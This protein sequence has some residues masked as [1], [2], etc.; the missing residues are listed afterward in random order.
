MSPLTAP[1]PAAHLEIYLPADRLH[2][3][4]RGLDLPEQTHGAALYADLTGFTPL[5]EKLRNQLGSRRGAEQLGQTLE[6]V[7]DALIAEVHRFGGSVIGFS[8]DAVTCWFDDDPQVAPACTPAVER[9]AAAGQGMQRQIQRF[10]ALPLPDGDQAQLTIKV[11]IACGPARRLLVGDPQVH[12]IEVIAGETLLRMA[13]GEHLAERGQVL[14]DAAAV[15]QLRSGALFGG[16]RRAENGA[17]FYPLLSLAVEVE[18][19]PWPEL[20][21]AALPAAVLRPWLLP[22]VY[23]RLEQGLGDYLTELRPASALFMK[24]GGLDFDRDPGAGQALDQFIR[25]VQGVLWRYDGA[26]AQVTLGEKGSFLYA[27][28]GA[29]VTHE[30]DPFRA[31]SAALELLNPPETLVG[32]AGVQIGLASGMLRTGSY[33]SHDR[34]SYSALGDEV[35]LAARLMQLAGPGEILASGQFQEALGQAFHWR[36]LPPVQIKGKAQPAPVA[37]LLGAAAA[38]LPA[39]YQGEMIGRQ[40]ELGQLQEFLA[41]L[42]ALRPAFAGLMLLFGDPGIGKSR[43]LFELRRR[44][45]GAGGLLWLEGPADPV[46]GLSLA[47][48]R[49]L[50]RRYFRQ[51]PE[52]PAETNLERFNTVLDDL[53]GALLAME[54]REARAGELRRQLEWTRAMLGALVDLYWP[55]SLYQ[56]LEPKQRF[57]NTLRAVRALLLAE[58]LRRPVV[59]VLED[60][61]A[62][63]SDSRAQITALVRSLRGYPLAVILAGRFGVGGSRLDIETDPETPQFYLDLGGLGGDD[64][65]LLAAQALEISPLAARAIDDRLAELLAEKTGGNPLFV[66]QLTHELRA[67]GLL[68]P[69]SLT[70]AGGWTAASMELSETPAS[71]DALLTARLDRLDHHLKA[72]V[73]TAAILG[74]EFEPLVLERMLPA[75]SGLVETL[76]LGLAEQIW[77]PTGERHYR[78]RHQLLRDA[79]YQMQPRQRLE[80]LHARA[81]E[82]IELLHVIDLPPYLV[83]LAYHF[84]QARQHVSAFRYAL[85]A[86]AQL[87]AQFANQAAIELFRQAL[88]HA[89]ELGEQQTADDLPRLHLALGELLVTAG[90]QTQADNHLQNALQLATT[91]QQPE[92]AA[93][94]CR[95]LARLS[96]LRGEYPAALEWAGRGLELLGEDDNAESAEILIQAGLTCSRQGDYPQA[97]TRAAAGLLAAERSGSLSAQARASNL[98]GHLAFLRGELNR[99]VDLSR[100]ALDLYQQAGDLGGM[101]QV[102]NRLGSVYLS[103]GD[104]PA[105][106]HH[107]NQARQFFDQVGNRYNRAFTENNLGIL[108]LN[109]GR[110]DDAQV[111]FEQGLADIQ[112]SGGSPWALGG[113]H[114]NLGAVAIRRGQPRSALLSLDTAQA[115]FDQAGARDWLPELY[116]HRS[117]ALLL[118]GD[119]AGAENW[120]S[121]SASLAGELNMRS[122]RGTALRAWGDSAAALGDLDIARSRYMES[123][124]VL[125]AAGEAYEAARTRLALAALLAGREPA[126]ARSFLAECLPVFE[127]LGARLDL[128]QAEQLRALISGR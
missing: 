66:E 64:L 121:Q 53:M 67:R 19:C 21:S 58:S 28:F 34:R 93:R 125:D 111:Y 104:W 23:E 10:Q 13:A 39:A 90:K 31:A 77:V 5:S 9:A 119:P 40:A 127:R 24:F 52:R 83:D 109:Q 49:Y 114:S 99:S 79:A 32:V 81:G 44:T 22:A 85:Q 12:K 91:Q 1:L 2:A 76:K 89:A 69:T 36:P 74:G 103:L 95:W 113:F 108:A 45:E 68:L 87:A 33:G 110:L 37:R 128:S 92:T 29:P 97:E 62:L 59:L 60:A 3:L 56:W 26:L 80:E 72:A 35:N 120:A 43:L 8:G 106:E 16:V 118:A 98:L 65:R 112:Q 116:R 117:S 41:P 71:L 15:Q 84:G 11:S 78:F 57:E 100:R 7:Y 122:E 42:F 50:L 102:N 124:E 20:P 75:E 86:G 61:H 82:A 94:A 18:P 54:N 25:W 88:G 105:A 46:L 63:D 55:G 126:Q 14:V 96:E 70:A 30:D 51:D 107:Y 17:V 101:A 73:Q 6:R 123:L 48:F 38:A 47:P 115:Y 27:V 4:A